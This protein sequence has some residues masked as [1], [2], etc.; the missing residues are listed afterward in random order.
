[1][2]LQKELLM[3]N[4]IIRKGLSV[5][6]EHKIA[7]QNIRTQTLSVIGNFQSGDL[8]LKICDTPLLT[9]LTAFATVSQDFAEHLKGYYLSPILVEAVA[10]QNYNPN[11]NPYK[12]DVFSLGMVM[13]ST[14]LLQPLDH[15]LKYSSGEVYDD[16]I[17]KCI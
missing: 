7:H 9:S 1:M 14:A 16:Q 8:T 3:Y 2:S 13:L 11:H 15:C 12:S 10:Q 17:E 6:Q 4:I 5:F